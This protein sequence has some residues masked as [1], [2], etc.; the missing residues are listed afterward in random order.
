MM[1]FEE[2]PNA[3]GPQGNPSAPGSPAA[4]PVGDARQPVPA[5]TD[6]AQEDSASPAVQGTPDAS[7]PQQTQESQADE[8]ISR[9]DAALQDASALQDSPVPEASAETADAQ[10][11]TLP[12]DAP[13]GSTIF[14]D[15]TAP[16]A[17]RRRMSPKKRAVLA[18]AA[19]AVLVAGG[20]V[21]A[22]LLNRHGE[23]LGG[24][25]A[26]SSAAPAI[27][28]LQHDLS[29]VTKVEVKNEKGSYTLLPKSGEDAEDIVWQLQ[30]Y[31]DLE[32]GMASNVAEAAAAL[33][34]VKVIDESGERERYGLDEPVSTV[35]VSVKD[36]GPYEITVGDESPDKSG[37]YVKT[38]EAETVY[39]IDSDTVNWFTVP[40][41]DLISVSCVSPVTATGEDDPYFNDGSLMFFDK[42]TLGGSMRKTPI[43]I[44]C[45]DGE[46][47]I[48]PYVVTS[49][50]YQAGNSENIANI[51][52]IAGSGLSNNGAFVYH[53]DQAD[54]KKYGLDSPY[55]TVVIK[56]GE[57]TITVRLGECTDDGYYPVTVDSTPVIYKVLAASVPWAEYQEKDVYYERL[58][59]ENVM[60]IASM[61]IKTPEKTVLFE[62]TQDPEED[63]TYTVRAQGKDITQDQFG[64]YYQRIVSLAAEEYTDES[65]SD[66]NPTIQ[67]TIRY[68]DE[69][70]AEDVIRLTQY[71]D[72]RYLFTLNGKGNA[73]V[74][75]TRVDELVEYFDWLLDGRTIPR[76]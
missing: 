16:Q 42:I 41:T 6:A 34:A 37:R 43:V 56:I 64:F 36:A 72:R 7:G 67:F 2:N 29:T 48:I 59:S 38:S 70:R 22:L 15:P 3:N 65:I 74:A 33:T 69:D 9:D 4:P 71:S 13:E 53:P 31:E 26:V 62:L 57:R 25:E 30:G 46:D 76:A 21:A 20:T 49:P 54:F 8:P 19:V 1:P 51:L 28:V 11:A 58:F 27:N 10:E 14:S 68:L 60:G 52:S 63:A 5:G 32:M 12:E 75:S 17:K 45:Y 44:E 24:S 55:S 40:S 73:L 23:E 35:A 39:L 47:A 50:G 61:E 18:L 66:A